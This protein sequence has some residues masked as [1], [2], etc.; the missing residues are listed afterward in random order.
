MEQ[1]AKSKVDA[2]IKLDQ[3]LGNEP[4]SANQLLEEKIQAQQ[5]EIQAQQK[6]IHA[7]DQ[8]IHDRDQVIHDRDEEIRKYIDCIIKQDSVIDSRKQEALREDP[9]DSKPIL[10]SNDGGQEV[11]GE[12]GSGT[13]SQEKQEAPKKVFHG[14]ELEVVGDGGHFATSKQDQASQVPDI[15]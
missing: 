13:G 6:E 11:A 10:K 15:S 9:N 14:K 7:R 4:S 12:Q 3:G 5:K 1:A 8:V 2:I